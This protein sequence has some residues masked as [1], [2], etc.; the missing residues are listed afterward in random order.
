MSC[1]EI[2]PHCLSPLQPIVKSVAGDVI[3]FPKP[4][5]PVKVPP[6]EDHTSQVTAPLYLFNGVWALYTFGIVQTEFSSLQLKYALEKVVG[7][8]AIHTLVKIEH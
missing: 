5:N 6:K 8:L 3:D 2:L 7:M 4:R 1:P